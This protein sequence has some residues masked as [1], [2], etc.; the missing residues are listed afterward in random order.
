MNLTNRIKLFIE[1]EFRPYRCDPKLVMLHDEFFWN[2]FKNMV[3]EHILDVQD[4][5][6]FKD[7]IFEILKL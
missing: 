7:W 1:Y 5:L 3:L 6:L 4:P 2:T